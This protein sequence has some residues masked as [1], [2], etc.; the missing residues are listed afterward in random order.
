MLT[1]GVETTD[2]E[3]PKESDG[4]DS[5]SHDQSALHVTSLLVEC[6]GAANAPETATAFRRVGEYLPVKRLVVT[7]RS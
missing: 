3:A 7:G 5:D 2:E 1:S 6:S 4:G